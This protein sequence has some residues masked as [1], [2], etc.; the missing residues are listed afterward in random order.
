VRG[1]AK[2]LLVRSREEVDGDRY[3]LNLSR[4]RL[5]VTAARERA[6]ELHAEHD[7]EVRLGSYV[8][9]PELR[10]QVRPS[11][12]EHWLSLDSTLS[13]ADDHWVSQRFFRLY[14]RTSLARTDV[15]VGRQRIPLGTGRLWSALDVLNPVNP[16]RVERDEAIGVDA[17]KVE[18]RLGAL[19]RLVAIWAPAVGG[20][21]DRAV[22]RF[23]TNAYETDVALTAG[24]YWGN[25]FVGVDVATQVRGAGLYAEL[26]WTSPQ[27]GRPYL[28]GVVGAG[29]ALSDTVVVGVE[30]Y[31][32]TQGGADRRASFERNPQL[33]RVQPSGAW[34]AGASVTWEPNPVLESGTVLLVN[35]GDGSGIVA[36]SVSYAFAEGWVVSAT[37]QLGTGAATDEYRRTRALVSAH[38][39]RWF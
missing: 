28:K 9:T 3:V 24:T 21:E 39:Q 37:A 27:L 38:L 2:S 33:L 15:T 16:L 8:G 10:E 32:T 30:A 26:A 13:S 12:R 1:Y 4:L 22:A 7:T 20:E 6:L 17:A 14:A 11:V 31:A 29:H 5:N 18:Q 36:P 23:Q 34:Y 19:T 35:L 25:R